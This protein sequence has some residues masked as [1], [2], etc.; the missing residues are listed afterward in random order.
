[1]E[2]Y[3]HN[4]NK[5]IQLINYKYLESNMLI[6]IWKRNYITKKDKINENIECLSESVDIAIY[7]F[8]NYHNST[9]D[10]KNQL[11]STLTTTIEKLDTTIKSIYKE[12]L[13]MEK[14]L[15]LKLSKDIRDYLNKIAPN[16]NLD[17]NVDQL[18]KIIIPNYLARKLNINKLVNRNK[19]HYPEKPKQIN[20]ITVISIDSRYDFCLMGKSIPEIDQFKDIRSILF[21]KNYRHYH[22]FFRIDMDL[23]KDEIDHRKRILKVGNCN[24]ILLKF[25]EEDKA[26]FK[27]INFTLIQFDKTT[28]QP[29]DELTELKNKIIQG[30]STQ[31]QKSLLNQQN[32]P[33]TKEEKKKKIVKESSQTQ[34]KEQEIAEEINN[35]DDKKAKIVNKSDSQSLSQQ[36]V[37]VQS[38]IKKEKKC[39]TNKIVNPSDEPILKELSQNQQKEQD[40][41]EEINNNDDKKAK[42]VNKSDSQSLS[43]QGVD[44]RSKIKKEK[45]C[46]TNKIVNPS[47]EPILKE[48]SQN[49]QKEQEIAEEINNNDDKKAKIVNKSDSQS[50]SQQGLDV[51]SKIKKEKKCKTTKI[52]NP[53]DEP[54]LKESSQNQQKEQEIAEEINNYDDKKAKIVNKSDSQSLSQQGVDVQS[55]IKKEKK[56]KTNKIVNPSDEPI[57]KELSQNQQKEQDIAEEINNNDDKKA[58]VVNKSDSQ[59]LSQQGVD[60]RS[61]IKK[62]KKCKTNKIV[63]PSDEPILKESSQNQQK[64]QEIAEE[65]NNNDDKKAKIVNKSDSQSLSQQGVDVRSKI[66]KEKKCKTNKIVNPSDEPI[67]KE[68]SQNQQKEQ[69]IAE[70]INNND[71]KKAKIVNKSDSQSLSQQGLDVR[72]KIKKE[73]KCKTN[74]IVNPSDE[75][76]LKES[77]QNQQKEQEITEEIN[78][79]DNT[80]SKI[81]NES[82]SQSLYQEF[83]KGTKESEE[84]LQ[85]ILKKKEYLPMLQNILQ[86]SEL[87]CS[88]EEIKMQLSKLEKRTITAIFEYFYPNENEPTKKIDE[89]YLPMLQR[90]SQY[91]EKIIEIKLSVMEESKIKE[92]VEN[93]DHKPDYNDSLNKAYNVQFELTKSEDKDKEVSEKDIKERLEDFAA[94]TIQ[95]ALIN[96]VD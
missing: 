70:E 33:T 47:D 71:D 53:S 90:I 13:D 84:M 77:S 37:D 27:M 62:E 96:A 79:Y 3:P 56:C 43:Q 14:E 22:D 60:V 39:K 12:Y 83:D 87:Q 94:R 91:I 65:I 36:G 49:Q 48:S 10:E 45:K 8:K 16:K 72:S 29:E 15:T 75:P 38:K 20:M 73:K 40:I 59:S 32:S 80:K 86:C 35:Y 30:L 63:N 4:V 28:I 68:S 69:E 93:F 88:E 25:R 19:F 34:Q 41:A 57:L 64:E 24:F 7:C 44:V 6:N 89:K 74:K 76:I 95:I 42:V 31:S 23:Q 66:K 61:K 81:E 51:R 85:D 55:K 58:K 46:K 2:T 78:N 26:E 17:I 92:I 11:E 21:R 67:L 50:L 9:E 5:L 54:I 1:M 82:D 18:G 52:V